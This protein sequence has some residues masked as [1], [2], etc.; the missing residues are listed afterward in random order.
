MGQCRLSLRRLVEGAR[1][2]A[3]LT[4]LRARW[5]QLRRSQCVLRRQSTGGRE[6]RRTVHGRE[7]LQSLALLLRRRP[8]DDDQLAR[9]SELKAWALQSAAA[10][11]SWSPA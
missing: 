2:P 7:P 10:A 3:C 1:E 11:V 9:S 4:R 5:N 6:I 8:H